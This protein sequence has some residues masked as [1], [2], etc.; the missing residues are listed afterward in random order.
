MRLPSHLYHLADLANWPSIQRH[1]LLSTSALLDLAEISGEERERIERSQR[2]QQVMLADGLL[3]RDQRPVAPS[4]LERCLRGI[5]PQEWY[6]LLNARVFFW[7]ERERLMR[8]LK[9]NSA[10]PQVILVLDTERLLATYAGSIELTPIN[11][12][13]A[14]R[15]AALRGRQTF[16]PYQTWLQ[17]G[18]TSETEALGTAA[19]PKS[20]PPAELTILNAVPDALKFVV[21]I[22][23]P[24]PGEL[25]S[26]PDFL[27][28]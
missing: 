20:H 26:L 5:T 8:M 18:W 19:R 28:A 7:P 12:G 24:P 25:F 21:S 1:G 3:I 4:A 11:T 23:F 15:K 13:N 27:T 17:S 9:A 2:L 16:V 22:F 6:A 10:R 14:R